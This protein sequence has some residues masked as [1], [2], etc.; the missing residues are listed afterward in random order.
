MMLCDPVPLQYL[1][2]LVRNLRAA[3]SGFGLPGELFPPPPPAEGEVRKQKQ[4][5]R[6]TQDG[7]WP[8]VPSTRQ[9]IPSYIWHYRERH[10]YNIVGLRAFFRPAGPYMQPLSLVGNVIITVGTGFLS[11]SHHYGPK[12]SWVQWTHRQHTYMLNSRSQQILMCY[13]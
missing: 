1:E 12:H 3:E 7:R 8:Q 11:R 4:R 2:A 10:I 13:N 5:G 6:Q 9:I